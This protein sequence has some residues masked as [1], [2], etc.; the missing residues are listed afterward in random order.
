[1]KRRD[2]ILGLGLMGLAGPALNMTSIKEKL[3]A[4]GFKLDYRVFYGGNEIGMQS[5]A[6]TEHIE[7]DHLVIEHD[8]NLQ[9]KILFAVAYSLEHKSREIWS[10]DKRLISV[11]A[12]TI[13]NGD[14][15]LVKGMH[16]DDGFHING[17]YG[18]HTGLNSLVTSDSFWI[19]SAM[20]AP[21]IMNVRTGDLAKPDIT[22]INENS[23]HL[24][25]D[26]EHGAV[27]AKLEY[28]ED[29]LKHA[30]ID[31]DGHIVKFERV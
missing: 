1:M 3:P 7:G 16:K 28:E 31:S 5:V 12:E 10:T 2:F 15:A 27:D 9:V 25:A 21:M 23:F 11:E 8:I 26:F 6:I 19:A 18:E 17:N 13:E 30:E 24:K 22:P 29:F 20:Q 4:E 14:K